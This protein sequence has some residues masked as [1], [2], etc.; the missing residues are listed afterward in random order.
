MKRM[1]PNRQRFFRAARCFE[2]CKTSYI[3]SVNYHVSAFYSLQSLSE[4]QRRAWAEELRS[5]C[6]PD[7]NGSVILAPDGVNATVAGLPA[8]LERLEEW[9]RARLGAIDFKHSTSEIRPFRRWRVQLR[10]ETV[11]CGSIAAQQGAPAT[12]LTPEEWHQ[13]LQEEG[14]V[15]VDVRNDYEVLIGK[16]RGAIDPATQKFSDFADFVA[17]AG[18]RPDQKILTYCTGGIRC[19]KA[20][21]YLKELGYQQVYQL[22]GGILAYLEKF[23]QGAFEGDCFI[24]DDRVALNG[25][26]KPSGRFGRCSVC[27]QPGPPDGS[28]GPS[29]RHPV[30]PQ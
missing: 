23:P 28:P 15:V 5:W 12:H 16:F 4:E 3:H 8:T 21:P 13:A 30:A 22:Q 14:V 20:V 6:E 26:L 25:E 2:R 19:E 27:G 29:C 7:L 24:F 11:T 1:F 9:F 17:R 18:W 10:R